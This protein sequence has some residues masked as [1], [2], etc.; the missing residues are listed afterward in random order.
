MAASDR[1]RFPEPPVSL[2]TWVALCGMLVAL[3]APLLLLG[4]DDHSID[5]RYRLS[6]T[7]IGLG[8]LTALIAAWRGSHQH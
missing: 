8:G 2:T 3:T 5:L 6:L 1:H 7:A 4:A